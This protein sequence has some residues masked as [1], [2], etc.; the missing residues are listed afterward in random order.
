MNLQKVE[1]CQVSLRAERMVKEMCFETQTEFS[2][3]ALEIYRLVFIGAVT[4][5]PAITS[6]SEFKIWLS[7]DDGTNQGAAREA[8]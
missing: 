7:P 3:Q 6:W 8:T 1:A 4:E 5:N 2:P